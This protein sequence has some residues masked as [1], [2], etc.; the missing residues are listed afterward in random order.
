MLNQLGSKILFDDIEFEIIWRDIEEEIHREADVAEQTVYSR[1][2]GNAELTRQAHAEQLM[3][4]I[5]SLGFA[6]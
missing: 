4:R 2:L 6:N 5:F 1:K 3:K